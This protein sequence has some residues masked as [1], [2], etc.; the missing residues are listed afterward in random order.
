M[1]QSFPANLPAAYGL[2]DV[3][4]DN[5]SAPEAYQR[6]IAGLATAGSLVPLF[7]RPGHPLYDLLG[8][9]YVITHPGAAL[10]LP[11]AFRDAAGWVFERPR[12]LPRLFLP[13]RIEIDQ[14]QWGSGWLEDNDDFARRALVSLSAGVGRRW[15]ARE[16]AA[17]RVAVAAVSG[18]RVHGRATLAERR[19]LAAS[20]Y[21]DGGWHVLAGGVP[22][23]GV[24]VDGIF[25]G[26]WLPPGA[27]DVDLIYRPPLLLAGCLL[28]A[29]AVALGCAWWVPAPSRAAV[30]SWQ[31]DG[32]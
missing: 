14:G 2:D 20:V 6:A 29:L 23:A 13:E 4:V 30:L 28:T 16:P 11:A 32:G 22:R 10:P 15:R 25:A 27:W 1:G 21:Q 19:L 3:R 31:G 8:V 24:L 26:A 5:P 9:R 18:E 12:P 17:S 7:G